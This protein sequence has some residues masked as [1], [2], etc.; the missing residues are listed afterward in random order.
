MEQEGEETTP[1]KIDV[2]IKNAKKALQEFLEKCR[3]MR[4][5]E[6]GLDQLAA[7]DYALAHLYLN[8]FKKYGQLKTLLRSENH[9]KLESGEILFKDNARYLAFLYYSKNEHRKALQ[10]LKE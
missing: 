9:L 4:V 8:E 7:I 10:I 3:K 2:R 1:L 5:D 6:F